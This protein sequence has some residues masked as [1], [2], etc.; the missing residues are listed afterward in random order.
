MT[1][2]HE[3]A[4]EQHHHQQQQQLPPCCGMLPFCGPLPPVCATCPPT[5]FPPC[6]PHAPPQQP[7]IDNFLVPQPRQCGPAIFLNTPLGGCKKSRKHDDYAQQQHFQAPPCDCCCPSPFVMM[8]GD[9]LDDSR[10]ERGRSSKV[11]E[12]GSKKHSKSK[13]SCAHRANSRELRASIL[14]RGCD[15]E[16]RNGLQDDCRRTGCHGSPECRMQPPTCAPSEFSNAK[17]LTRLKERGM[18]RRA[19]R[20]IKHC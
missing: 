9:G 7:E 17:H 8:C 18:E 5:C 3:T 13:R 20:P 6:I 16:K 14:Y 11:A 2:H 19:K 4:G 15:C 10:S 12:A 1:K